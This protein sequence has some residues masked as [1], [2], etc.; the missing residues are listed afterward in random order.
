MK[1]AIKGHA[2]RGKEVIDILE[3]LSGEN[4]ISSEG[5]KRFNGTNVDSY[6]T[7]EE[8]NYIHMR[9]ASGKGDYIKFTLEEFIAK[10][11]YKV[12]DK[13][14]Y[15]TYGIYSGIRS[16]LW[17]KEKEQVIYR[18]DSNKLFVAT[19]DELQPYKEETM[20][21]K[22]NNNWAKWDLPDGYEFQDEEGNVIKTGVIK[23]VKKQLQYP[24]TYEECCEVLDMRSD[25]HLTFEL[26]NATF[27]HLCVK[28]GFDYIL[29]LEA[30]RKLLIC[31]NAYW[32]IA[33]DWKEKRKEK[34]MHYVICSTLLGEVVKDTMPNCIASYLLD[35]PTEEMR[36]AF[37]ENFKELIELV[38]ELL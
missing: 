5:L 27:R 29:S 36:D 6:Y 34:A 10:Y 24:K 22:N 8:D 3:M 11:P 9:L 14:L 31:R 19:A 7:I 4:R 38:N 15:K 16:M 17:N 20:E 2:I 1:L 37:Y 35:F 33:G 13:V 32:K 23:L 25:W 26:N 18:L 21:E 28:N 12:G 30:F